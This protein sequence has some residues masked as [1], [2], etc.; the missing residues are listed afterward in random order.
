MLTEI[1]TTTLGRMIREGADVPQAAVEAAVAA[2]LA[3]V[4][5]AKAGA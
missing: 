2:Y 5:A 3:D 4:Y 1:L